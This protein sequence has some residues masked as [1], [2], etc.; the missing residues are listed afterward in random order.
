M[1]IKEK[2]FK[3][4]SQGRSSGLW[5]LLRAWGW[6]HP[7][8]FS[9]W[10]ELAPVFWLMSWIS[11]LRRAVR[12]PV[13]GF[14]GSVGSVCLCAV[15]PAFAV[16]G[17]SV[18]A[19]ASRWPLSDTCRAASP[20]L[21]L[22]SLLKP[23]F[24]RPALRCRPKLAREVLVW[25][26]LQGGDL[27]RL[28]SAPKLALW[29][30]GLVCSC[31]GSPGL[32]SASRGCVRLSR[33]RAC[34]LRCPLHWLCVRRHTRLPGPPSVQQGLCAL[35]GFVCRATL[36]SPSPPSVWGHGLGAV[37][38]LRS[39]AFCLPPSKYL[40]C[41]VFQRLRSSSLG[42]PVGGFPLYRNP[43][44]FRARS[45][46]WGTSSCPEVLHLSSFDVSLPSATSFQ[47][48]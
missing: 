19:A 15:H 47:G 21:A 5:S 48:A 44:C 26:L 35:P 25:V 39:P 1:K 10:G 38:G 18:S 6:V 40:L 16:L 2:K 11:S 7:G 4:G 45:L 32:P 27:G 8:M 23:L 13:V 24:P 3:K 31:F 42:P 46:P 41:L 22:G 20:Y 36:G 34:T 30:A 33:A 14:G 29:V 9:W 43:S 28:P 17:A 37:N 12:C